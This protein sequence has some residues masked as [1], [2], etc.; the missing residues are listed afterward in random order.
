MGTAM[1]DVTHLMDGYRDCVRLLWNNDFQRDAAA[2][3]DWDLRDEFN[4]IA[5]QLFR[6]L[7]LRKLGRGDTEVRPDH[8]GPRE[9]FPFLRVLVTTRGEIMINRDTS[10]GCWDHPLQGIEAGDL[11]LRFM[12]Y[13][14]WDDLGPKDLAYYRVRIVAS[15]KHP[16]VVGKDALVAVGP[17]VKVWSEAGADG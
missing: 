6:T 9:P 13:F 1:G 11:D 15:T 14:D 17:L 16:D 8:W 3:G 12:Q 10:G 7:V 2:T 4:A 5:A